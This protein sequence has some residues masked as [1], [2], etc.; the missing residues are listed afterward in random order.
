MFKQDFEW[1][2]SNTRIAYPFVNRVDTPVSSGGDI[3]SDLVVDAYLTYPTDEEKGVK[4]HSLGEPLAGGTDVEFRFDDETVALTGTGADYKYSTFG[5]WTLL[6]W[7]TDSSAARVLLETAKIAGFSWPVAL[8]DAFLVGHAVQP[9]QKIV[10]SITAEGYTFDGTVELICGYNVDMSLPTAIVPEVS[11]RKSTRVGLSGNAGDGLGTYPDCD[12]E[13]PPVYTINGQGPDSQG[14][15]VLNMVDCYRGQ[16][17]VT[18]PLLGPPWTYQENAY[19]IFNECSP[20]C[21][22]E[23]YVYVYDELLRRVFDQAQVVSD[24]FYAVRD[25][26]KEK[27][28]EM[29]AAA[30]CR[31]TPKLE[32]KLVGRQG[33]CVVVQVIVHNNKGCES[34][35]IS[36]DVTMDGPAGHTVPDSQRLDTDDIDHKPFTLQ[37]SWPSYTIDFTDGVRGARSMVAKFEVYFAVGSHVP[38]ASVT[39]TASGT[40]DGES[41]SATGSTRLAEVFNKF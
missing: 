7:T 29:V 27:Y 23:D 30:A 28:D 38:G 5:D 2:T 1:L 36:I 15:F 11:A 21:E 40:V 26:Y 9:V 31:E 39:A 18:N 12:Y 22:C 13:E 34:D 25:S 8:T 33:W 32:V 14:N 35:A 19:Q 6:E 3:F 20:C 17:P 4:L 10:K 16:L 24:R 41:V 37:G